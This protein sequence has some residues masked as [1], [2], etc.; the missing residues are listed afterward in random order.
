MRILLTND[1]GIFAPGIITLYKEL[2][3]MAEVKVVAPDRERS[4]TSHAITVHKPLRV[5]EV[6]LNGEGKGWAVTGTP[7]DCVKLALKALLTEEPDLVVSGINQ[8]PNLG[9]DVLYSGTVSA[10]IE[11]ILHGIPSLAVS[12]ATFEEN[13]SFATAARVTRNIVTQ[14][15]N[16]QLPPRTLL[17]INIPSVPYHKLKGIKVT[18]L[19][20]RE[21]ENIFEARRD[22]RGK[23]YYWL[24]GEVVDRDEDM[25]ELDTGAVKQCYVSV[26]P[27]HFDL[28]N[29]GL[30]KEVEAWGLSL[31]EARKGE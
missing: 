9:T 5:E 2:G 25:E 13:P 12:L 17:N 26:T 10:A 23:L 22:P 14:M 20:F 7:S 27:I 16:R 6:E 3:T 19:G 1:D 24:G 31:L 15:N 30:L 8:G 29:Y 28:T 11:G 4:A 18:R 21:Y